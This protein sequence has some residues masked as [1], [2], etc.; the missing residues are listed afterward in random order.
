[1]HPCARPCADDF[2]HFR[3]LQQIPCLPFSQ[4][5][6][7]KFLILK[8]IAICPT[9]GSG[10]PVAQLLAHLA[11]KLPCF[12]LKSKLQLGFAVP[13]PSPIQGLWGKQDIGDSCSFS[14]PLF[15][16]DRKELGSPSCCP[17]D[18]LCRSCRQSL[19]KCALARMLLQGAG[20]VKHRSV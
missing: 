14:D 11:L 19:Y 16:S 3:T 5:R 18:C 20:A 8:Q 12:I 4:T 9:D 10:R 15:R 13:P 2:T 1:M 7:L 17:Y 6:E